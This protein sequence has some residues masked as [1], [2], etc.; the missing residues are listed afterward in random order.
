VNPASMG[1]L[2]CPAC[3]G[4]IAPA[5]CALGCTQCSRFF[6]LNNGIPVLLEQDTAAVRE[7]IA[8]LDAEMA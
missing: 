2:R 4:E 1:Y 8:A 3:G 6:P 7:H 5:P